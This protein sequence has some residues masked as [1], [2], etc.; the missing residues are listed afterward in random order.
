LLA[1]AERERERG[2]HKLHAEV[3]RLQGRDK[4]IESIGRPSAGGQ[5]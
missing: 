5:P 2:V 1:A 3:E 4:A